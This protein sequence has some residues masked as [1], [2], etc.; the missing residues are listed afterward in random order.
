VEFGQQ[1]DRQIIDTEETT[2][3]KGA[4]EGALP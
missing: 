4:K 1:T 3:L 2:V